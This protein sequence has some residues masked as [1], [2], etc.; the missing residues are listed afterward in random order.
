MDATTPRTLAECQVR[1]RATIAPASFVSYEGATFWIEQ[2][3]DHTRYLAMVAPAAHPAFQQFQG[4][5][6]AFEGDDMILRGPLNL[7]N[8][9]ALRA[10]LPWLKPTRIGLRA[11][12]GFGDR[13]GLATP[14]HV[15]ALQRVL[16][17]SPEAAIAPIFAQQ[18]IREMTRT[19]RTPAEVLNDATWGAFL[20]GW[21]GG[22]G[23]DADHL[24]TPADI[25]A[26]A[27][28]GYS[29]Y[30][31]DPGEYV[32]SAADRDPPERIQAKLETL[33]WETLESTL[34]DTT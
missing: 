20:A 28:V 2:E 27:A 1:R 25:D 19:H 7:E 18:S 12:A 14:G 24:K 26:C 33:P 29:F 9:Q 32:D 6:S 34:A 5:V 17:E 16:A 8:A 31:F 15:R 22:V 30:T 10:T 23:A 13:L 4:E 11:S 3:P 21:Q